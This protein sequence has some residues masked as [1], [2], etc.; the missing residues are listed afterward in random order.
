MRTF[1]LA[2]AFCQTLVI[3]CSSASL[4]ADPVPL[5]APVEELV[6]DALIDRIRDWAG[7]PI[8]IDALSGIE[9]NLPQA[10]IDRLDEQWRKER[11]LEDQPLIT[12][13]L[14]SPLSTYLLRIQAQSV[15]VFSEI[16]V[17]NRNGLNAG[18]SGITS[19]YWQGDEA[20]FQ[21]TADV[22]PQVVFVDEP[23]YHEPTAT[24][25][26]QINMSIADGSD[27]IL[28]AV[29]AEVNLTELERRRNAG[30]SN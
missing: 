24:W 27:A 4:A 1:L 2:S 9:G 22:G 26:V 21:K 20:K 6:N 8:V 29:T 28:G 18:Q 16:F 3:G 19:D 23:E 14:A 11:E 10:E 5:G 30:V 13:V 7:A 12:S 15:G 17:M 25:R